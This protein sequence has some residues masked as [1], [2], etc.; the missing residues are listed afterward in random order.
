MDTPSKLN[1]LCPVQIIVIAMTGGFIPS[2][3][4]CNA[5]PPNPANAPK[6]KCNTRMQDKG[7]KLSSH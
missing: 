5:K 4:Q 1:A 2:Q 6:P 7:T 3:T